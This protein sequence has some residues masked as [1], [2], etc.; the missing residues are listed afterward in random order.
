[1]NKASD[2]F[3]TAITI[4]GSVCRAHRPEAEILLRT[5]AILNAVQAAS[6][7]VMREVKTA[8]DR[9]DQLHA[10]I[11]I[12]S[13]LTKCHVVFMKRFNGLAWELIALGESK[14]EPFTPVHGGHRPR[15]VGKHRIA[16]V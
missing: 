4:A 1:M 8:E 7:H 5:G 11:E 10:W 9:S 3:P 12:G 13:H 15:D 6:R 2:R 14:S 16:I